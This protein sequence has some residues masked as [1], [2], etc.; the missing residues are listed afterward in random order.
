MASID[1]LVTLP[2]IGMTIIDPPKEEIEKAR[3]LAHG[4]WDIWLSR[5][6]ADGK[7]GF[8]LA[9]KALGR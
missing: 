8:E 6:G 9:L 1:K 4:A 3:K 7:R 2:E 5:T